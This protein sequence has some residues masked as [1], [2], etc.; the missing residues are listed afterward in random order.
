MNVTLTLIGQMGTFAVLIWFV[1]KFL[2]DPMLKVME[3]RQNRIT[4]GLAAAER[5]KEQQA[6]AARAAAEQLNEAREQAKEI[7]AQANKRADEIVEEAKT[8]GRDEGERM[9][10][11]AQVEIDQQLNQAREQLRGEVVKLALAGA[12]QILDREVD[13]TAHNAALEKLAAEL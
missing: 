11:L 3:D 5:G 4:E 13:A 12:A 9:K 10:S 8:G 2:W 7:I 1:M 6:A